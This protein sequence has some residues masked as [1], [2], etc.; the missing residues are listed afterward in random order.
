MGVGA[1][2]AFGCNIGGFF[3]ATS[4]L[5]MAGLAMMVGLMIGAYLGLRL[6]LLEIEYLPPLAGHS[7]S[8]KTSETW[9]NRQPIIGVLVLASGLALAFIYDGFD[10]AE[11]GGI[12]LFGLFIGTVMQRTRFCFVRAFREPFMTGNGDATKAVALA[13]IISVT[14][15]SILKWTDLREWETMVSS[16]FWVGSLIGGIIFGIGMSFT[17]GCATG[18]MWRA[19]EGQ[20]KLWIALVGFTFGGSYFRAWMDET[21]WTSKLGQ[22]VFIPDIVGWKLGIIGIIVLML[23]WYMAASWNEV[24][25]K[26]VAT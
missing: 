13:I 15:F 25:G 4:A 23:L 20:V 3:S 19:A 9:K 2:M 16:G 1:S 7:G 18:S 24:K 26:L 21:G 10:Y 11:R 14:G 12:L 6:L 22:P 17:G 5:S 8:G